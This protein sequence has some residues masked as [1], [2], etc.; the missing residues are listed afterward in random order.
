MEHFETQLTPSEG[1]TEVILSDDPEPGVK[2]TSNK[3]PN[4]EMKRFEHILLFMGISLGAY[5]GSFIR[6]GISYYKIWRT[7]TNYVSSFEI[8]VIIS[9]YL[10]FSASCTLKS[11]VAF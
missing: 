1:Y 5:I 6:I 3:T 4:G 7:E 11:L 2:P 8:V 9:D 10:I